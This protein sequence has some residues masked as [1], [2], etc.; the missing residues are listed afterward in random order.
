MRFIAVSHLALVGAVWAE[1]LPGD[2]TDAR[3]F[4]TVNTTNGPVFGHAASNSPDVLEYLGIPYAKP[5][6]GDLRFA[7][8]ERFRD[9]KPYEAAHFGHDC[10]LTP[11]PPVDYPDLT[12]QAPRILAYFASGAGTN[13]SEDCL[14]LNIWAKTTP[15]SQQ[16]RKPVIVFFY[17]GRK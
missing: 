12:P 8:P 1:T 14:T 10:P 13:K 17:G 3:S 5:P 6:V 9:N 4:L 16:S 2:E 7:P 15:A 11:S